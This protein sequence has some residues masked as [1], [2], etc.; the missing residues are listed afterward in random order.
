MQE[1]SFILLSKYRKEK[2]SKKSRITQGWIRKQ[3]CSTE[4]ALIIYKD[5]Y[6]NTGS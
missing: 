6:K 1:C 5:I 2:T 3:K 4:K